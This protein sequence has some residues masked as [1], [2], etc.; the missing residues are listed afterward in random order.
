ML[1]S[2]VFPTFCDKRQELRK[3]SLNKKY[4]F[5]FLYKFFPGNFIV[6]RRIQRDAAFNVLRYPRQVPVFIVGF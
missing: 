3:N 6:V 4:V 1:S 2:T 5:I